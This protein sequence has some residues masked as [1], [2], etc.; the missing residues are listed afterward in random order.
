MAN[1]PLP[2]LFDFEEFFSSFDLGI[3]SGVDPLLL[4]L[5]Q[6]SFA[7]NISTRGTFAKPRPPIIT[8][9][10]TF[11]PG[12]AQTVITTGR[13]QGAAYYKPDSGT[14]QL[15]AQ[16]SGRLF[17]F[18]PQDDDSL[19]VAEV[20]I[21]GDPN[22]ADAPQ[23][24]M[25]QAEKWLI[26]TNGTTINPVFYDGTSS[27][28]SNYSVPIPFSTTT[29][30]ATFVIPT[31]GAATAAGGVT[32]TTTANINV[33][34]LLTFKNFGQ[35]LVQAVPSGTT[36]TLV[37]QSGSPVGA[38]VPLNTTVSW[39]HLGTE[40]PPG[41]MGVYG[42][43]RVWMSLIDGKQF[44]AGDLV[45]GSS[46]T[47]ANNYRD[48]VLN[49]T[50][51][52]YLAGGGNFSVPG[53]VGEIQAMIFQ[54][55]LDQQLGQGPLLVVTPKVTFSC[56][57]PVDRTLWTGVQNPIVTEGMISNGGL[58]QNS[59]VAVNG[60]TIMRAVDGVRSLILARRE[61]NTWGNTPISFEMSRVLPKDDPALLAFGSAIFFDNRMLMT[62]APTAVE[63]RGVFH[64]GIASLN[65]DP[66][67]SIRGKAP[68]IW[69]GIWLGATPF[70]L[71]VG[72]F[73]RVERGWAFC[74]NVALQTLEV[75]ELLSEFASTNAALY[76]DDGNQPIVYT[77]ETASAFKDDAHGRRKF[78][79]LYDGEIYVD[80]L[81]GIVQFTVEYSP[82]QW[83]GWV[84]WRQWSECSTE[85]VI[86]DVTTQNY[87]PGFRPRM[88]LGTP[89]EV[90]CDPCTGRSLRDA[91][92]FQL[93]V[94][95]VGQCRFL[96]ARIATVT[97]PQ[98]EFAPLT[99]CDTSVA[100]SPTLGLLPGTG[101]VGNGWRFYLGVVNGGVAPFT[102]AITSGAL[103]TGLSLNAGTGLIGGTPSAAG[104][105]TF[106]ITVTD[107]LGKTGSRDYT[108]VISV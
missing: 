23:C 61:F 73:N 78:K 52:T 97:I 100:K 98:P 48:S 35:F 15:V 76:F 86:G 14:E 37:N 94:T 55:L 49:I 25:W 17:T 107:V 27:R 42:L 59:T 26:I 81:V 75:R 104:T 96:G 77:F 3:N 108:I 82:D 89:S 105:Y 74:Y 91:Y 10:M 64:K 101:T 68:S 92:T 41:R 83:S 38:T 9:S 57:S 93:R 63:N 80:S 36:L 32:V 11:P 22:S 66:V 12:D 46:G 56:Q 20:T 29:N 53:S 84:L 1:P 2:K 7:T 21:A 45:G 106:R 95:I 51:N 87:Q 43:G 4:P 103:P 69:E 65:A 99:C 79:Q 5:N 90:D 72:T 44:I 70:Q 54:A 60:D 33:G 71:V 85:R 102:F 31:Q 40:L 62:V 24:W 67:S 50:E 58:S 39:S 18:T 13:F 6:L 28:R 8:R 16:I 47:Q 88:G 30:G 19:L 34:D